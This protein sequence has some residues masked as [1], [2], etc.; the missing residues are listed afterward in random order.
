MLALRGINST[1]AKSFG[2]SN[3]I[4]LVFNVTNSSIVKRDQSTVAQNEGT[5][6]K[7]VGRNI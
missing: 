3:N 7:Y 4:P 1:L 6:V 5:F 2:I